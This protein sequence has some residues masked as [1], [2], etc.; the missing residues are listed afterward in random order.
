MKRKIS[1]SLTLILVS[2][3]LAC[4]SDPA[5]LPEFPSDAPDSGEDSEDQGVTDLRID[6][7]ALGADSD[8]GVLDMDGEGADLAEDSPIDV[9]DSEQG[10]DV[11]ED[12]V[13]DGGGADGTDVGDVTD[14]EP[15]DGSLGD[16]VDIGTE[17]D[18]ADLTDIATEPDTTVDLPDTADL[19]DAS[20]TADVAD[21]GC[22]PSE[23]TAQRDNCVDLALS[24]DVRV[25][26][27]HY[28][29]LGATGVLNVYMD[30][31]VPV[32]GIQFRVQ[33][34]TLLEQPNGAFAGRA[35]ASGF[36]LGANPST[37]NV[38][39]W[40]VGTPAPAIASGS[41]SIL[42]LGFET[43]TGECPEL[44]IAP[45]EDIKFSNDA[46]IPVAIPH[47]IEPCFVF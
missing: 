28:E 45:P 17:P 11:G 3:V 36:T 13:S 46:E 26:L 4:A 16:A 27:G 21:T 2:A 20:D 44:C 41:G 12:D 30:N 42:T 32:Y 24:T 38:L 33:G 14:T 39:G 5:T 23:P 47:D 10:V 19:A 8:A 40:A 35:S 31:D 29:D 25:C 9:V 1:E 37:G 18:V 15:D 22:V 43:P 6:L 7:D 34:V